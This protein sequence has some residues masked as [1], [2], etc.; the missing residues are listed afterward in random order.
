MNE[1]RIHFAIVCASVSCPDLRAE[2]FQAKQLESQLNDQ[3]Q[4][5]LNNSGKGIRIQDEQI[6][7][8]KI[9]D[10]FEEE[11]AGYGGEFIRSHRPALP[12]LKLSYNIPYNW[13]L[14]GL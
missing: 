5:F 3:L 10:W 1:P 8:S 14:N 6:L 9:Y 13:S 11:F 12:G 7:L 4:S 2:P